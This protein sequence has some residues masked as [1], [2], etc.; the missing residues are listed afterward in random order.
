MLGAVLSVFQARAK[1][2]SSK[3]SKSIPFIDN[4]YGKTLEGVPPSP[5]SSEES[6][7]LHQRKKVKL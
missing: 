2:V 4:A 6:T 1:E 5:E 7:A 3:S